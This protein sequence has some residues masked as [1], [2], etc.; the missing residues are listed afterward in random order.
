[1]AKMDP[2]NLLESAARMTA[3]NR[4]SKGDYTSVCNYM[5]NRQPLLEAESTWIRQTEDLITLRVGRE[6][7]L[8][9]SGIERLLKWCHCSVLEFLF[10]DEVC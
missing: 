1:M 5:D 4:P 6:H 7:A 2:A 8:L 3:L 10:V 9:D